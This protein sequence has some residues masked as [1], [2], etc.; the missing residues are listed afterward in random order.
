MVQARTKIDDY[1]YFCDNYLYKIVYLSHSV[2]GG[3]FM[4]KRFSSLV[5]LLMIGCSAVSSESKP[6]QKIFYEY[7]SHLEAEFDLGVVERNFKEVFAFFDQADNV[8]LHLNDYQESMYHLIVLPIY[9]KSNGNYKAFIRLIKRAEKAISA[10]LKRL[11]KA[12][13]HDLSAVVSRRNQLKA[14]FKLVCKKRGFVRTLWSSAQI[15]TRYGSVIN[16]YKSIS[17][18]TDHV[19]VQDQ[20]FEKEVLYTSFNLVA[21]KHKKYPMV[22]FMRQ[23]IN[24][25]T[26][27]HKRAHDRAVK[28]KKSGFAADLFEKKYHDLTLVK[29]SIES[30]DAYNKEKRALSKSNFRKGLFGVFYYAPPILA[31]AM[32]GLIFTGA[33]GMS[34]AVL[35]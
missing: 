1:T 24:K 22:Y 31:A 7:E 29:T 13:V 34:L 17:E 9:K 15:E 16:S 26:R 25:D 10:I 12:G 18:R 11:K 27:R 21:H 20:D 35:L 2:I 5:L 8:E 3:S 28:M 6:A 23:F 32:W 14:L 30:L 4:N 33:Y 19:I